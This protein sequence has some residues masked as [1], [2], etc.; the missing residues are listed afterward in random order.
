MFCL[1]KIIFLSFIFNRILFVSCFIF[2]FP[3][4]KYKKD[5]QPIKDFENLTYRFST[6]YSYCNQ[7]FCYGIP[8][9]LDEKEEIYGVCIRPSDNGEK[10]AS[11]LCNLLGYDSILGIG[12]SASKYHINSLNYFKIFYCSNSFKKLSIHL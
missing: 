10:T 2:K 8:V 3:K 11:F 5:G 6:N 12:F 4:K 7:N 9:I 1:C